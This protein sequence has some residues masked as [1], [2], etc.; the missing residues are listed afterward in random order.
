MQAP[1]DTPSS[2]GSVEFVCSETLRVTV[3][4]SP[5]L[6]RVKN[7]DGERWYRT[8][9]GD[10]AAAAALFTSGTRTAVSGGRTASTAVRGSCPV[11]SASNT[12]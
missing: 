4:D 6:A 12:S 2:P 11:T 5:A 8:G 9:R 10:Y 7:E 3:W 1:R